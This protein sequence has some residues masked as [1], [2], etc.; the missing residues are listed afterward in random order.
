M[1]FELYE[2]LPRWYKWD[3]NPMMCNNICRNFTN[4]AWH[5][6]FQ[7]TFP[8]TLQYQALRA[9]GHDDLPALTDVLKNPKFEINTPID[10]KYNLT[11]LQIA[12]IKNQYPIIEL[13]LLY[14]ANINLPD[15][16]GN[17][18]LMLAV[19]NNSLEAI[20]SLMKNGCNREQKN[21][22]GI[23]PIERAESTQRFDFITNFIR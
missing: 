1:G 14:G 11:A 15:Q 7:T 22:Y 9:I 18:P 21:K 6:P 23:T 2:W 17:S 8:Y 16:H 3:A 20:N 10:K 5:S 12:A 13:L 4:I 19:M